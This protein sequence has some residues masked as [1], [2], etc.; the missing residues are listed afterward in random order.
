[1]KKF[2]SLLIISSFFISLSAKDTY[3][4]GYFKKNG[5]YVQ[6]HFKTKPNKT[7]KDNYSSKGKQTLIQA[8]RVIKNII[9]NPYKGIETNTLLH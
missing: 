7:K 5:T 1:M 3:N 2:L 8:K 9:T 6:P 4:K